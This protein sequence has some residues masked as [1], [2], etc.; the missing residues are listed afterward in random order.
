MT[1]QKGFHTHML[2]SYTKQEKITEKNNKKLIFSVDLLEWKLFTDNEPII[3]Q[4]FIFN[5]KV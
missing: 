2:F 4:I 3:G 1:Y 5:L